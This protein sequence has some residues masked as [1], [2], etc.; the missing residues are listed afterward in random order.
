MVRVRDPKISALIAIAERMVRDMEG[1]PTARQLQA[2]VN[3]LRNGA[4]ALDNVN[5]NRNPVDTD[6]AH[7]VKVANMARKFDREITAAMNRM[8]EITRGGVQDAQRRIDEKI[9][10]RPNAFAQEIRSAFRALDSKGK[11]KLI[12]ELVEQNRGPELA[13]IVKAPSVLTGISDEQRAVYEKMIVSKHAPAELDEQAGIESV[14]EQGFTAAN[15]AI[16]L[17]KSLTDPG[18]LAAIERR[19]AAA[20]AAGEAFNQSLQ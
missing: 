19:Q 17:V 2:E 8:G 6:A 16:S 7:A 18:K 3:R 1:H 20:N 13:A 11:A 15:V 4:E 5:G 14:F 12:G 9:D 10:L